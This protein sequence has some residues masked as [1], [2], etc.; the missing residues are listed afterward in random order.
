LNTPQGPQKITMS[1]VTQLKK[2]LEHME[3]VVE[4]LEMQADLDSLQI[5]FCKPK[6]RPIFMSDV[7]NLDLPDRIKELAVEAIEDHLHATIQL[8]RDST[9]ES[10][11]EPRI[12]ELRCRKNE[13][14]T[15]LRFLRNKAP[16]TEE[17]VSTVLE[18]LQFCLDDYDE[19]SSAL[20]Q[21]LEKL[22]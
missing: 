16:I 14:T 5:P 11:Q 10:L 12:A 7:Q 17:L 6:S 15:I 8:I 18:E 19:S 1:E 13:A 4:L 2:R 21:V 20:S 9:H 22:K 3:R